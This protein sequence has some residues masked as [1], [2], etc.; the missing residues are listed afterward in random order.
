MTY[1]EEKGEAKR[2]EIE[3]LMAGVLRKSGINQAELSAAEVVQEF[4]DVTAPPEEWELIV[5]DP[6]GRGGGSTRKPGNV[7]LNLGKLVRAIASG[8]LAIT[9]AMEAKWTL[10]VAALFTWNELWSSLSIEIGEDVACVAWALWI[11]RDD[12]NTVAK[13][14][15]SQA[16]T[17]ERQRFGRQPLSAKEVEYA[18]RDLVRMRCIKQSVNDPERWW[19]REWVNIKYY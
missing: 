10:M 12:S 3:A 11:S 5:M 8:T 7:I 6:G 16:V 18:L 19:L 15:V 14:E 1:G 4:A 9:G 17:C 13:A 2:Q